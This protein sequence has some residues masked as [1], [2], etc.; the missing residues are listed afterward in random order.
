MHIATGP[1]SPV[2]LGMPR[3]TECHVGIQ[4][5]SVLPVMQQHSGTGFLLFQHITPVRVDVWA[6]DLPVSY[7]THE[8]TTKGQKKK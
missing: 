5:N 3:L 6:A 4:N 1:Y 2:N 8:E 7:G